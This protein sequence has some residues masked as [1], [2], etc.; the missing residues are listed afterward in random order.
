MERRQPPPRLRGRFD[1]QFQSVVREIPAVED[2]PSSLNSSS[3]GN[4][5]GD[6]INENVDDGAK[7]EEDVVVEEEPSMVSYSAIVSISN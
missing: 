4:A 6:A 2:K 7:I 1:L 5:C 3:V